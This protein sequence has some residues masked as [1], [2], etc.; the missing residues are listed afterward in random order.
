MIWRDNGQITCNRCANELS[1][2]A[3]PK[4]HN[5]GSSS[6]Q[7]RQTWWS[8]T[9]KS[10]SYTLQISSQEK[11]IAEIVDIWKGQ[12][13]DVERQRAA[14]SEIRVTCQRHIRRNLAVVP[15]LMVCPSWLG[16][17]SN[18]SSWFSTSV[19]TTGELYSDRSLPLSAEGIYGQFAGRSER[20]DH[21]FLPPA[22][23]PR[24]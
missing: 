13:P 17:F 18:S 14:K 2:K 7:W 4:E 1:P 24:W 21:D 15:T 22:A 5:C 10:K 8:S 9:Q 23:C 11:K 12:K 6:E 3:T 16:L 19:C 20:F